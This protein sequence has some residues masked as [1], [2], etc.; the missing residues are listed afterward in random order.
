MS[1]F[2][3][4]FSSFTAFLIALQ[5][6]ITDEMIQMMPHEN[7]KNAAIVFSPNNLLLTGRMCKVEKRPVR[8]RTPKPED[9]WKHAQAYGITSQDAQ[10]S[11]MHH[12]LPAV[13]QH[14]LNPRES[15]LGWTGLNW[16]TWSS[17]AEKYM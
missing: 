15:E 2:S 1:E 4:V 14:N 16:V 10:R 11:D 12:N 6:I 7:K 13:L 8:A 17:D 5:T 9:A 3:S